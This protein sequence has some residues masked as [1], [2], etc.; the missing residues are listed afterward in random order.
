MVTELEPKR[1]RRAAAKKKAEAPVAEP[2]VE[3]A[4][5]KL[6][7]YAWAWLTG[8]GRDGAD[9]PD[10]LVL[11]SGGP[12]LVD[13]SLIDL[14]GAER[15]LHC[16]VEHRALPRRDVRLAV[17]DGHL[18]RD[19][20]L[21][22]ADPEDCAVGDDAVVAVVGGRSRD[23]DHFAFGLGQPAGTLHQRVVIGKEGAELVGAVGEGEEDVGNES[24]LLLDGAD[25]AADV[26]RER[27]E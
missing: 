16:E 4:A 10:L 22:R 9:V 11:E 6:R 18:V 19:E 23:D 8:K 17:V 15:D 2:P 26:V 20:R 14:A 3:R 24:R 1:R 27:V 12:Q 25:A 13:I 5:H 21:L 7:L